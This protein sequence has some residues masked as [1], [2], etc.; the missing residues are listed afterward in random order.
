M[1]HLVP[2]NSKVHKSS[3]QGNQALTSSVINH[4]YHHHCHNPMSVA[5]TFPTL[6][7][8]VDLPETKKE[9]L[10][11]L[12]DVLW[13]MRH[14]QESGFN[15]SPSARS[16]LEILSQTLVAGLKAGLTK[17]ESIAIIDG[18]IVRWNKSTFQP[19]GTGRSIEDMI[20]VLETI[21]TKDTAIQA[22][23][24]AFNKTG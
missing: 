8:L 14:I 11:R 2:Q 19:S 13:N 6:L 23:I 20:E 10:L 7:D 21:K 22:M 16:P 3:Y 5:P 9:N 15:D 18:V 12:G 17:E 4:H 24:K 1:M